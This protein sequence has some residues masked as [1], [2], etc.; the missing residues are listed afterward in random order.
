MNE[1]F[2]EKGAQAERGERK[3]GDESELSAKLPW[4]KMELAYR[5]NLEEMIQIGGGK[6]TVKGGDP[7]EPRKP[8]GIEP[9]GY[10]EP[11]QEPMEDPFKDPY[12]DWGSQ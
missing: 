8:R 12:K 7:G 3:T 4:E 5:G 9:G 2:P 1:S 11:L 6:L 10:V